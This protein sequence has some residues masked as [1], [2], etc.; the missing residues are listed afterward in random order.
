MKTQASHRECGLSALVSGA[1]TEGRPLVAAF[2]GPS[3]TGKTLSA[4]ALASS[5]QLPLI[6]V[7]LS[8]TVSKYIGET[9]KNLLH[10]LEAAERVNAILLF[11]EA[12]ALFGKRTEVKDAH[13]RYANLEVMQLALRSFPGRV[14]LRFSRLEDADR[15]YLR[16]KLD[17]SCPEDA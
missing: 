6:R 14:L 8:Q 1:V 16:E 15:A 11:D 2:A 17:I 9:E 4:E 10:L 12:D 13:D 3:G 7:D 5:L